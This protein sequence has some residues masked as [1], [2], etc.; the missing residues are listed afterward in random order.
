MPSD[1]MPKLLRHHGGVVERQLLLDAADTIE[2]LTCQV[3]E[4]RSR[5]E[6]LHRL[7]DHSELHNAK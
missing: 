3:G 7:L 1:I 6:N 5:C 4:L 2:R